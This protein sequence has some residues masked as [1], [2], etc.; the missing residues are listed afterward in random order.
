MF[1]DKSFNLRIHCSPKFKTKNYV[2]FLRSFSVIPWVLVESNIALLTSMQI[3]VKTELVDTNVTTYV[4]TRSYV[5]YPHEWTLFDRV[6]LILSWVASGPFSVHRSRIPTNGPDFRPTGPD[7]VQRGRFPSNGFLLSLTGTY[8]SQRAWMPSNGL[9]FVIGP[10]FRLKS[11]HSV[12]RD[13]IESNGLAFL[14]TS[15]FFVQRA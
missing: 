13:L 11:L 3:T 6:I 4:R 10:V 14:L 1:Y 15:P 12:Q 7:S 2:L 5:S 8:S 9:L